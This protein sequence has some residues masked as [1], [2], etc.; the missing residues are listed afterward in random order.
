MPVAE[1]YV[2]LNGE[3]MPNIVKRIN[4]CNQCVLQ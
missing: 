1:T 2:I 4:P 3:M